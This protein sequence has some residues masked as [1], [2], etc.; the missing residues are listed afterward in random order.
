MVSQDKYILLSA[1]AIGM[2]LF[3]IRLSMNQNANVHSEIVKYMFLVVAITGFFF[4]PATKQYMIEDEVT[5]QAIVVSD[6]PIGV[7]ETLHLFSNF[8]RA[9]AKGFEDAFS[10][11]NSVSMTEMGIGFVMNAHLSSDQSRAKDPHL[12]NTFNEYMNNCIGNAVLAGDKLATDITYSDDLVNS[13]EVQGN[14]FETIVYD[15]SN[16]TGVSK[17]CEDA[18]NQD[19]RTNLTTLAG[20]KLDILSKRL[21]VSRDKLEDGMSDVSQ[22]VFGVSKSAQDYVIQQTLKNM[23]KDGLNAMAIASGGDPS[24][25]AFGTALASANQNSQWQLAGAMAKDNLPMMK[26]VF[27]LLFIG[28]FLLLGLMAIIF[29]QFQYVKTIFIILTSL[30]LWS[31]MASIINYLTFFTMEWQLTDVTMTMADASTVNENM[32]SKLAFF[33]YAFTFIPIFAYAVTKGSEQ[34]FS[35][36]FT[37]MGSGFSQSAMSPASQTS[38]GNHSLGNARVGGGNI[39]DE[40][41]THNKIGTDMYQH[42]GLVNTST[43]EVIKGDTYTVNGQTMS[44]ASNAYGD[45]TQNN[46]GDL[47]K[48]SGNFNHNQSDAISY[49]NSRAN[50]QLQ[51]ATESFSSSASSTISDSL[52]SSTGTI[53][54][55]TLSEKYGMSDSSSKAVT[56][57]LGKSISDTLSNSDKYGEDVSLKG[58][59]NISLRGMAS[60]S[61]GFKAIGNGVTVGLD[62]SLSLSGMKEDGSSW[63]AT[64]SGDTAKSIKK[65]FTENLSQSI[66]NDKGLALDM[67][68]SMVNNE[69][70][71]NSKG[72][73]DAK[74]YQEALSNAES[75]SDANSVVKSLGNSTGVDLTPKVIEDFISRDERLSHYYNGGEN[76]AKLIAITEAQ[77]RIDKALKSGSG[78]DYQTWQDSVLS[79]TGEQMSSLDRGSIANSVNSQNITSDIESGKNLVNDSGINNSINSLSLSDDYQT[80]GESFSNTANKSIDDFNT[81]HDLNTSDIST[82]RDSLKDAKKDQGT[83]FSTK[84]GEEMSNVAT[85]AGKAIDTAQDAFGAKLLDTKGLDSVA[86]ANSNNN[87]NENYSKVFESARGVL[88]SA[89]VPPAQAAQNINQQKMTTDVQNYM[90]NELED[91]RNRMANNGP[92]VTGNSKLLIDEDKQKS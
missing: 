67:S 18:W 7:G 25:L 60:S 74:N 19:I 14:Y 70:F 77:E 2:F 84:A 73:S 10:T 13:L 46:S 6:V 44:T 51:Q 47:T 16:P 39:T 80:K 40:F 45:L 32:A 89:E 87:A 49:Q 31:P 24:S 15:S 83:T 21:R 4:S 27:Q 86:L 38:T 85:Q 90:K 12:I 65:D 88:N 22:M 8:E 58:V 54:N 17:N 71:A 30:V 9:L 36:L 66:S 82:T 20:E 43:G 62:G 76:D 48:V 28:I 33:Q 5:G 55:N 3:T 11:P 61:A 56:S 79:V 37:T 52:T 78:V 91:L 75:W 64:I 35:S 23:T 53:D 41:G 34:A 72:Y 69:N 63:S 68:K 26:A 42:T 57:S 50:Q 59:D 29:G 1:T 81:K 92:K